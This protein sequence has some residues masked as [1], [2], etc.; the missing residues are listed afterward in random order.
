MARCTGM[1]EGPGTELHEAKDEDGGATTTPSI[2]EEP[3]A[4]EAEEQDRVSVGQD[5]AASLA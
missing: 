2:T 3:A 4:A 5:Q 1:L